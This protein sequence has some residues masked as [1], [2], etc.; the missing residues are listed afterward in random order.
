[1]TFATGT[2][3][4]LDTA[5]AMRKGR[6]IARINSAARW[7]EVLGL[8][9]LAPV[10]RIAVGDNVSE[11]L[12]ELKRVLIIPLL[13]IA[14]FLTAW[15]VLAPRVQTSLG[16]IPGPVQVWE[17]VGVLWADHW[18]ER[19][20]EAAFYQRLEARNAQLVAGGKADQVKQR[21]YTGKPTYF[22]QILT[23]LETVGDSCSPQSSLCRLVSHPDFP[24][25]S[26]APSIRWFRSSNRS[27]LWHGCQS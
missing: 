6:L 1:M 21:A 17:Q 14:V 10:L 13:G 19:E 15:G 27:R 2:S 18:A 9:W 5:R 12:G 11:Q 24:R 23:S 20:K 4:A 16:A 7:L 3:A 8:A 25:R 26:T 22:D